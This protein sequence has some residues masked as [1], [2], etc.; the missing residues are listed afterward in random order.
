M[1][2]RSTAAFASLFALALAAGGAAQAQAPRDGTAAALEGNVVGGG[3]ATITG[4]GDDA[5]VTYS[6][7]GAGGGM[8]FHAQPGRAA[9]FAGTQGDGPQVEYGPPRRRA[10]SALA[11]NLTARAAGRVPPMPP[12]G[13]RARHWGANIGRGLDTP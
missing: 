5:T 8:A 13:L 7:G 12:R 4:G 11:P 9:R 3:V 6:P 2:K 10:L 1:T